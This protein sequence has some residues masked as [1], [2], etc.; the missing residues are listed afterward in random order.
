LGVVVRNWVSSCSW[1]KV[2]RAE[3]PDR[4]NMQYL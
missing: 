1:R 2:D 4:Q 3:A